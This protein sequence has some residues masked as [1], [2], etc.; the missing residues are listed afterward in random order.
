[1]DFSNTNAKGLG[2]HE[3]EVGWYLQDQLDENNKPTGRKIRKGVLL[4]PGE[5]MELY[6]AARDV[7]TYFDRVVLIHARVE[8]P[9]EGSFR[10]E[11]I[12]F[13]AHAHWY[14]RVS[15]NGHALLRRTTN[16]FGAVIVDDARSLPEALGFGGEWNSA[17]NGTCFK[18][19]EAFLEWTKVLRH[20]TV[21][22][23]KMPD[24]SVREFLL[25]PGMK[26]SKRPFEYRPPGSGKAK[27]GE[28]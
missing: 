1:M 27:S 22:E 21:R 9:I 20:P 10:P 26:T 2:W 19:H 16:F 6:H 17:C 23:Q 3:L 5:A 8:S 14:Q 24:G 15:Y 18:S 11:A 7:G 13:L 12:D 28:T 4:S 25:R